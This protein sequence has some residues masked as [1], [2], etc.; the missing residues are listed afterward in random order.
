LPDANPTLFV[1]LSFGQYFE[2]NTSDLIIRKKYLF[3]Q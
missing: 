2:K 3:F 1:E